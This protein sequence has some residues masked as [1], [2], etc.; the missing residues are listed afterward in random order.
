MYTT[1]ENESQ[2]R[3]SFMISAKG[4]KMRYNGRMGGKVVSL[5]KS[6]GKLGSITFD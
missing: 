6:H 4:G 2:G 3:V 1:E 5:C